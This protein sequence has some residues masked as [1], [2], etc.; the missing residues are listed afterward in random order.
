VM[1]FEVATAERRWAEA[2]HPLFNFMVLTRHPDI[3]LNAP[4]P[5]DAQAWPQDSFHAPA[6]TLAM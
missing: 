1:K 4:E 3:Q 6:P 2:R 5:A